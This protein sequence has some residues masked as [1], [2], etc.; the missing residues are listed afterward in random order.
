M[1]IAAMEKRLRE[2]VEL[3]EGSFSHQSV[4]VPDVG[5]D[6]TNAHDDMLKNV[7][8]DISVVDS[9]CNVLRSM[10]VNFTAVRWSGRKFERQKRRS[11]K[12]YAQNAK[13]RP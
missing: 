10:H 2:F 1:G 5:T 4:S 12:S 11:P 7:G 9:T 8:C 13:R 6:R 3:S